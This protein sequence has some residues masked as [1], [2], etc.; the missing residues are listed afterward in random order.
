M[1]SVTA[2][3]LCLGIVN[4]DVAAR[5]S[6]GLCGYLR[7][8]SRKMFWGVSEKMSVGHVFGGLS[9]KDVVAL[10]FLW[11]FVFWGG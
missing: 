9:L 1:T 6:Q 8:V 3:G 10:R 7:G 4:G 11:Y 2:C 5:H